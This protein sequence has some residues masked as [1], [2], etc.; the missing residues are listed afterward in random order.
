MASIAQTST[1][2]M[3]AVLTATLTLTAT[4][5]SVHTTVI[6]RL[7]SKLTIMMLQFA[8]ISMNVI[9]KRMTVIGKRKYA[10]TQLDRMTAFAQMGKEKIHCWRIKTIFST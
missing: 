7:D 5:Q 10:P 8:S 3:L 9:V 2:A 1:N 6:V 4:I